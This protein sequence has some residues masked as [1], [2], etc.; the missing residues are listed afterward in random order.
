MAQLFS[1]AVAAGGMSVK[2]DTVQLLMTSEDA[3]CC[4]CGVLVLVQTDASV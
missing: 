4:Q 1:A 3:G 2:P